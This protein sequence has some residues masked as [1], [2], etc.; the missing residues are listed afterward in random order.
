MP[1]LCEGPACFDVGEY[2]VGNLILCERCWALAMQAPNEPEEDED[3]W[4]S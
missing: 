3:E 1:R 4:H 2:H